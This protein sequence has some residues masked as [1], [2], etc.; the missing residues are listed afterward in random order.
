MLCHFC[1]S[2]LAFCCFLRY[3]QSDTNDG[4][5]G[6][7]RNEKRDHDHEIMNRTFVFR[8]YRSGPIEQKWIANVRVWQGQVCKHLDN[9]TI[10]GWV[11]AVE[12]FRNLGFQLLQIILKNPRV[13]IDYYL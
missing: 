6:V 10:V 4:P 11:E 2:V 5:T 3:C 9:A 7:I 8:A 13:T 1:V 12:S